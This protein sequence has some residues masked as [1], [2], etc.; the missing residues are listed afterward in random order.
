MTAPSPPET[1]SGEPATARG[2]RVHSPSFFL[3]MA[4]LRASIYRAPPILPSP[5]PSIKTLNSPATKTLSSRFADKRG[6]NI[7]GVEFHAIYSLAPSPPSCLLTS[8]DNH[9][10]VYKWGDAQTCETEPEAGYRNWA[11]TDHQS[12]WTLRGRVATGDHPPISPIG[13]LLS[14]TYCPTKRICQCYQYETK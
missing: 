2:G 12:W 1:R 4:R 8:S 6:Y 11:Y 7:P 3:V 14:T 10:S 9:L 13:F 5:G